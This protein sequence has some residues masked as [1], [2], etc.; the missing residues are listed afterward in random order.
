MKW[1]NLLILSLLS[2]LTFSSIATEFSENI[3]AAELG[4]ADAQV[5]LGVMYENG[6]G[7][8]QD[9]QKA[10]KWYLNA[11]ELGNVDAQLYLG[12]M[13]EKGKGVAQDYKQAY[14]WFTIAAGQG[15]KRAQFY[16]GF[17]SE[18]MFSKVVQANR[19]LDHSNLHASR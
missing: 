11:A 3:K 10:V 15:Y 6:R 8:T 13:Y 9:Y 14:K 5:T 2:A 19:L 17:V 12:F 16:L 1:I 7:V 18:K 4:D